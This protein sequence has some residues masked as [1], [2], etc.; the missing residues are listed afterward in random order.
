L[1]KLAEAGEQ[2]RK[3]KE[4]I[5]DKSKELGVKN[6]QLNELKKVIETEAAAAGEVKRICEID[7]AK[8]EATATQ[9]NAEKEI[10]LRDMEAAMPI[11]EEA[12]SALNQIRPADIGEL[13]T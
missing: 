12:K 8:C 7:K 9:V 6:E 13:K 3:L 1:Q 2:I 5:A 10:C 4:Q 11:L